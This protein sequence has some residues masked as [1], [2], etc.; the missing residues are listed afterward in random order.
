MSY[1][2]TFNAP[3]G[4]TFAVGAPGLKTHVFTAIFSQHASLE[5]RMHMWTSRCQTDR[6]APSRLNIDLGQSGYNGFLS[7]NGYNGF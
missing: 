2:P 7:Y 4:H 5:L 1:A 6:N 3:G